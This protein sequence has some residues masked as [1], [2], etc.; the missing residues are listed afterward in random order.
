MGTKRR[1]KLDEAGPVYTP[2][3]EEARIFM[4]ENL[5]CQYRAR[6]GLESD[7][8]LESLTSYTPEAEARETYAK[9]YGANVIPIFIKYKTKKA[10]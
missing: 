5:M 2:S 7:N 3:P 4:W 1:N 10:A 8:A 9:V 6:K